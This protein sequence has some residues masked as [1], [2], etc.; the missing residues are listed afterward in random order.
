MNY[1]IFSHRLW[2]N[3]LRIINIIIARAILCFLLLIDLDTVSFLSWLFWF[4]K[5]VIGPMRSSNSRWIYDSFIYSFGW[6]CFYFLIF[7]LNISILHRR[8]CRC[9]ESSLLWS[10]ISES[11]WTST[12][13]GWLASKGTFRNSLLTFFF[14]IYLTYY[15]GGLVPFNTFS[16]FL[17]DAFILSCWWFSLYFIYSL[18]IRIEQFINNLRRLGWRL[19]TLRTLISYWFF[20]SIYME[21]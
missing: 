17:F 8:L 14:I 21:S 13:F 3:S 7:P 1:I 18:L 4:K 15:F 9:V 5:V 20:T 16:S 10:F 11:K 2:N 19:L 12:S 6:L